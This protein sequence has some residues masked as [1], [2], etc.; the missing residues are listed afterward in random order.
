MEG[1]PSLKDVDVTVNLPILMLLHY[2]DALLKSIMGYGDPAADI[3]T[4]LYTAALTALR[5]ASEALAALS[6]GGAGDDGDLL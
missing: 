2:G 5:A 4:D 6:E 1:T 3:R